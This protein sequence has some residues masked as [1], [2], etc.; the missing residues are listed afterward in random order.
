MR[1]VFTPAP[2][3]RNKG[4]AKEDAV[5]DHSIVFNNL[6]PITLEDRVELEEDL[7]VKKLVD[8]VVG[9]DKAFAHVKKECPGL[10][11]LW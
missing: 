4:D 9:L 2:K 1:E 11:S 3:K 10:L 6:Q 8:V 5:V 7:N